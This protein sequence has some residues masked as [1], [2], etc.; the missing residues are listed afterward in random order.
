MQFK[1][2]LLSNDQIKS[3]P[4]REAKQQSL[5]QIFKFLSLKWKIPKRRLELRPCRTPIELL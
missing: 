5:N 3:M 1:I 4:K 2:P